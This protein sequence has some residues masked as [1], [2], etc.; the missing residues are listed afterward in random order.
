MIHRLFFAAIYS[1]G[2]TVSVEQGVS[3]GVSESCRRVRGST[4]YVVICSKA[5]VVVLVVI[6]AAVAIAVAVA[7]AVVVVVPTWIV[8]SA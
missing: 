7:A 3:G 8:L 4:Q 6:A 5:M 2:E 1:S